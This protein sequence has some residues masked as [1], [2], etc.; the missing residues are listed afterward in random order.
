MKGPPPDLVEREARDGFGST[1]WS[2]VLEAAKDGECSEALNSLCARYWRPV[3]VHIRRV[4][5]PASD[6]EHVPQG[7][8]IYLIEKSW[9]SH[10]DTN[11][12]RFAPTCARS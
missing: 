4:G 9:I 12:G 11:R 2:L 7:F 6:A 5:V 3:Y 10:A 1:E 8:F